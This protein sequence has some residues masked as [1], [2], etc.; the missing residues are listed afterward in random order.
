VL[1]EEVLPAGF[2][3]MLS[4]WGGGALFRVVRGGLWGTFVLI[5]A[6]MLMRQCAWAACLLKAGSF[7]V[8]AES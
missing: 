8:A 3:P 4:P 5:V 6:K 7:C 1:T 2:E